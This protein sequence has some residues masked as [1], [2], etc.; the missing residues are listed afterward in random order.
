VIPQD[1]H[2]V[3]EVYLD[4]AWHLVDATKMAKADQMAIIGAGLDA[5]EVSFLSSYDPI[6]FRSQSVQVTADI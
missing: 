4:N 6:N 2:A 3:A 5:A 1:F